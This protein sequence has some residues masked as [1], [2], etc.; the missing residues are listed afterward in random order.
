[1]KTSIALV[2]ALIALFFYAQSCSKSSDDIHIGITYYADAINGDDTNGDGSRQFPFRTI[3]RAMDTLES[4]D[5]LLLNNGNYGDVVVGRTAGLDWGSDQSKIAMPYSKFSDWVTVKA[6]PEQ[7]PHFNTLSIGTLNIPYSG[8]PSQKIDFSQKGNCDLYMD[9]EGIIIDDGIKIYGSRYVKIAD[10]IINRQGDLNGSVSN[11]DNKAGIGI[12]NGRFITVE[13]NE[14]THVSIGIAA[15]S[16]DLTI[17][18]NEI[19]HNSHDGIRIWGGDNWLVE[20]NKI[21]DID[22]G[23]TDDSGIDWNRHVDG[24]QIWPL[25]DDTKNLTIRGNLFYHIEAMGIMTQTET[26]AENWTFEDNIFGP[27]G[28]IL[29]HLGTNVYGSCI[30]RHNTVIY[31]PNDVWESIYG[32][33]MN[34]QSYSFALWSVPEINSGYRFYNNIFTNKSTVPSDFGFVA[35]NI[36]YNPKGKDP[37]PYETISGTITEYIETGKIPG[38]LTD[39]SAAIDAGTTQYASQDIYDY[40]NKKRDGKPDIGALEY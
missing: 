23:V 38:S 39:G 24:I 10:C 22:D 4:G 3:D 8:S 28:G 26:H 18:N 11:M 16:Y 17:K 5:I 1:M 13:G 2:F 21:H 35:N 12:Q 19:H 36:F 7:T 15:G 37:C 32:R 9:F 14:I 34:T 33:T 30:F 27:V 40:N 31:A 6:A 29:F 25:F 20:G